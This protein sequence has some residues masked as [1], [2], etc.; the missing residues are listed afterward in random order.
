MISELQNNWANRLGLLPINFRHNQTEGE[1][2]FAMLNGGINNFCLSFDFDIDYHSFI[3]EVWSANMSNFISVRDD[4]V[5]LYGLYDNQPEENNYKYVI[6]N[7]GRFYDYLGTK[8]IG[9]EEN[10]VSFIIHHFRKIRKVLREEHS[11]ENSLKAFLYILSL[12]D[13]SSEQLNNWYLPKGTEDVVTSIGKNI[14]EQTIEDLKLGLHNLFLPKTDLILRHCAG[15]LFQEANYIAHFNPQLELFPS[16]NIDYEVNPKLVG[17]YFT[18]PYIA[19]TI[20]EET[21]RTVDLSDFDEITIFDPA[22]GSGVFLAEALRQ[23]RCMNFAKKVNIIGWDIDQLAVDMANYVMQFE[24]REWMDGQLEFENHKRDSLCDEWPKADIIFMNPP[25]ISWSL[26]NDVQREQSIKIVGNS[27]RPNMAALFY[28]LAARGLKSNGAIGCLMPTSMLVADSMAEIRKEAN[29]LARPSLVCNIG[30]FVFTSAFVDVSI[31]ISSNKDLSENVQMVWVKNVDEVTPLALRRLRVVNNTHKESENTTN[32]SIYHDL[33]TRIN[34]SDTWLPMPYDGV[35]LKQRLEDMVNSGILYRAEDLFEIKQGARTGANDVFIISKQ[36]F[37]KLPSKEKKYFRPSI[38]NSSINDGVLT[39]SNYIF[40]PYPE[41]S[42]GF[43]DEREVKISIP[44][45]YKHILLPNKDKLKARSGINQDK[46]WLLTRPRT[47]QFERKP[48]FVSTEFGRIGSF[49]IDYEGDFVVERGLAWDQKFEMFG[50]DL[51]YMYL[52]VFSSEYFNKLLALYSRQ[53]A[54]G[55][56]YNLE[57]KYVKNIPLPDLTHLDLEYK[58]ILCDNGK[59]IS[60]VG[61]SN[62]MIVETII[63]RLYGERISK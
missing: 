29:S 41:D 59:R 15:L 53:L 20:V 24:K 12:I 46:W 56:F 44:Y 32:Y 18:P 30:N 22:C 9:K 50:L 54:G 60:S 36:Q 45:I 33:F 1:N 2:V 61:I 26:M 11:A 63:K 25:Y 6:A 27:K 62:N 14:I 13:S 5:L 51:F 10:V 37:S 8:K 58:E 4:K 21:L 35:L 49:G 55:E 19:R 43:N 16:S 34:Q 28:I 47:W 42:L 40:Y 57:T 52:S 3:H 17:S 38:D 7:I 39:V 31:I 23:L 48:K